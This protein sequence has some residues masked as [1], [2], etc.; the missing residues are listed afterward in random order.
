[1]LIKE[2]L[3]IGYTRLNAHLHRLGM[4]DSP[5]CPWCPTRHPR[6]PAPALSSSPLT[7]CGPP[8]LTDYYPPTQAN[9]D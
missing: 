1:M 8:P 5:H 7:P 2:E 3:R 6:T 4:T 9:T